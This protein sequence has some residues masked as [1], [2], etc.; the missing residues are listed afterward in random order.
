MPYGEVKIRI[1]K[2]ELE[3]EE[4]IF[5]LFDDN[6]VMLVLD[7]YVHKYKENRRYKEWDVLKIYERLSKKPQGVSRIRDEAK[8][9]LTEQIKQ[10]ALD[11]MMRYT[12][13]GFWSEYPK[14]NNKRI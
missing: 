4:F 1:D 3:Y 11:K 8:V 14:K 9:P 12:K 13:V 10:M 2:G 6:P 5:L 7:S